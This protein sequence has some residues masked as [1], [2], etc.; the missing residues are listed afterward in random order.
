MQQLI[1]QHLLRAQRKM[2]AQADKHRS[3]RSFQTG[4]F[5]FVKIQ[6][7]V[8]TSLASRS[9]NKLSFRYFGPFQV[10]EKIGDV[11]Y[12]LELPEGCLI[13]PVF[14]VSLLKKAIGSDVVV[15]TELPDSSSYFQVPQTILDR[16]FHLRNNSSVPQ[17]LV[18]WS[19]LP[20]ELSTWEDEVSLRQE[21][22]R[23]PAWGQAV[24]RGGRDV[25]DG[26]AADGPA[27]VST[28]APST[29]APRAEAGRRTRK[30]NTFV[31]GPEWV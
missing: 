22:P 30:P 26:P 17:V 11:A 28:E 27:A 1:Q 13:H 21:F 5:V 3:F 8:Q 31:S 18:K 25:T 23:A 16:R 4:E 7:Y 2:K 10:V 15:H 9:S 20:Q 12:R 19:H 29:E 14:H 6:P 24:P